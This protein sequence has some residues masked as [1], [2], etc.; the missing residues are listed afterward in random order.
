[1]GGIINQPLNLGKSMEKILILTSLSAW[2]LSLN[3]DKIKVY[4]EDNQ[5]M[6]ILFNEMVSE[7]LMT[8]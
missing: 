1:M 3:I 8:W 5:F 7:W 6:Y 4:S 2:I